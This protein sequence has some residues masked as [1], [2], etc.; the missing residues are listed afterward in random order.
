V[1]EQC[2]MRITLR[3]CIFKVGIVNS[4]GALICRAWIRACV[5]L[6]IESGATEV[7]IGPNMPGRWLKVLASPGHNDVRIEI[8]TMNHAFGCNRYD[9]QLILMNSR[10]E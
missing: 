3:L 7:V 10:F 6:T 5:G 9:D 2:R 4:Q 1:R 8:P